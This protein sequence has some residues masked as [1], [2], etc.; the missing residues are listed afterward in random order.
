VKF[1]IDNALSPLIA[2]GLKQA[3]YDAVHVREYNMQACSD[4]LVFEKA[5]SEKRVLISADTDFGTILALREA[6]KPSVIL[7]HRISERQPAKQLSILLA[8]LPT[9]V[10]ELEL[11]SVVVFEESRIRIRSLPIGG[12]KEG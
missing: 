5:S 2:E 11:G 4:E 8:N 10:A 1:L 3:G 6:E 9:I 12:G 7:F